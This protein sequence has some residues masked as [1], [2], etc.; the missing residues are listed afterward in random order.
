[1]DIILDLIKNHHVELAAI[2]IPVAWEIIG[3]KWPG[4]KPLTKQI[5]EILGK[6]VKDKQ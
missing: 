3:R 5:Y 6:I 4:A 1:M 2:I